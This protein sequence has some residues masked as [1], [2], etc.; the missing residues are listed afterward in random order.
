VPVKDGRPGGL[1][2][3]VIAEFSFIAVTSFIRGRSAR[4]AV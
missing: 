1:G 2:G 3:G 4:S